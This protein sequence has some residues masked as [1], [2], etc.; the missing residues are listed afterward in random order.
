[1]VS[2]T[3][4]ELMIVYWNGTGLRQLTHLGGANW[5]PFFHPNN[6]FVSTAQI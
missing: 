4:M 1:M 2:P 3:E 5:A 6:K